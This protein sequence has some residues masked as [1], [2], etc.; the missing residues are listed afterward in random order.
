[1]L[2]HRNHT[3]QLEI[4]GIKSSRQ[5]RALKD[6]LDQALAQLNWQV[7]VVTVEELDRLLRYDIS[8]IPAL[9]LDGRVLFQKTIPSVDELIMLLSDL[10][11]PNGNGKTS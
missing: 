3:H 5:M 2:N 4:L 1:M 6:N 10:I 9:A 8:G 7:E 11:P